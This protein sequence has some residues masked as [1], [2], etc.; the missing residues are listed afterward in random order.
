MFQA[1]L[2]GFKPMT[3]RAEQRKYKRSLLLFRNAS[4]SATVSDDY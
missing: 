4:H 1:L 3:R 2:A